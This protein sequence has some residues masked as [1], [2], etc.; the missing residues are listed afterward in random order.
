MVDLHAREPLEGRGGD[1]VVVADA[2]DGRIGIEAAAGSGCGSWSRHA[3]AGRLAR[4]RRAGRAPRVQSTTAPTRSSTAEADEERA[5]SRP[6]PPARRSAARR[7][8][9]R[10]C[11]KVPAMPATVATSLR[12]NRSDDIVITVTDSVWCAKPPRLSSAIADVGALD[13]ADERHAHHQAGAEREG[14]APRVDQ[15]DA[16]LL[17]RHARARRRTGSRGRR[18]GTAA[19]RRARSASGRSR[20]PWSGRAAPRR[21]A[22][23]RSDRP[24]SAGSAMP[25]KLRCCSDAQRSTGRV[26]SPCE[27]RLLPGGDVV[28]LLGRRARGWRVGRLVEPEPERHPD[29]AERAR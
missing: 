22:C 8:A 21:S 7:S 6:S 1:V 9:R 2:D 27:V 16:A 17:Q 15:A 5:C 19:R 14:P 29:E 3:V 23:P 20:A 26:P 25:Q 24:G 28:A 12:L 4:R 10:R 18:P 11:R 13:E